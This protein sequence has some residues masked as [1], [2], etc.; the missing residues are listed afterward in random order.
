[1]TEENINELIERK[2]IHSYIKPNNYNNSFFNILC[3][4]NNKKYI[5]VNINDILENI[6]IPRDKTILKNNET[7]KF[8]ECEYL[9]VHENIENKKNDQ[10]DYDDVDNETNT[11]ED[12]SDE[13][14]EEMYEYYDE[15]DGNISE[16]SE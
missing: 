12:D 6:K 7:I 16:F 8:K 11:N 14:E 10:D 3:D 1:M 5:D 2:L 9:P 4:T 13:E 15:E